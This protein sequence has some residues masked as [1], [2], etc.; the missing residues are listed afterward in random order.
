MLRPTI[1]QQ[2]IE[3]MPKQTNKLTNANI[4]RKTQLNTTEPTISTC[5]SVLKYLPI[6]ANITNFQKIQYGQYR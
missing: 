3:Q 4:K 1:N 6:L 2:A 5:G